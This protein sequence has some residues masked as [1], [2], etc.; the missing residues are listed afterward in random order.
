MAPHPLDIESFV[1]ARR[2]MVDEQLRERGIR[3]RRVLAAMAH[4][5]RHEFVADIYREEAYDDHPVPIGDGQT[6]SQPFIVALMLE[7]LQLTGEERV[8]EVGTG[9]GYQA[10][11]LAELSPRVYSIE[12]NPTLAESAQ[13]TL[14]RLGYGNVTVVVGDGG[15]GLPEKA[16]FD[17]IVVSAAAPAVPQL[18]FEQLLDGGR[19][20]VPVGPISAQQLQLVRKHDDHAVIQTREMCRFVPLIGKQGYPPI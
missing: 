9:S 12:R 15:I 2:A 3:D 10:A 5:P 18:L 13:S 11:L 6:I 8:L 16:P 4:V 17:A 14:V 19:M 20:I 1:A 7:A